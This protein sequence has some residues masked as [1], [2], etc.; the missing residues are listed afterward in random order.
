LP[1][2]WWLLQTPQ[3]RP[4]RKKPQQQSEHLRVGEEGREEVGKKK[5]KEK[6]KEK[7]GER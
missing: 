4:W 7:E 1:R 5:K 3:R 6:E 2:H